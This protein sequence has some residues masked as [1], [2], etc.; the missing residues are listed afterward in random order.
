MVGL[1]V[2]Q[3]TLRIYVYNGL[4]TIPACHRQTD[5][6]TF[7]DGIVRAMHTRHAVKI[8]IF[9]QYL[10]AY[11][12]YAIQE[13]KQLLRTTVYNFYKMQMHNGSLMMQA[14]YLCCWNPS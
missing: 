6:Q 10:A 13:I 11:I 9:D 2:G 1:P 3:K 4:D 12:M 14:F 7:C 5:R 8:V